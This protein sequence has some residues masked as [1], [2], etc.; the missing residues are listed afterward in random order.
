MPT[1][2][3]NVE[4]LSDWLARLSDTEFNEFKSRLNVL[5]AKSVPSPAPTAT[6]ING[7]ETAI[8][9]PTRKR[10]TPKKAQPESNPKPTPAA[11][12]KKASNVNM[13]DLS[14]D[15]KPDGD[16]KETF[17][18]LT[19]IAKGLID[20]GKESDVIAILDKVN[21]PNRNSIPRRLAA[22]PS[23]NQLELIDQ[24]EQVQNA[25]QVPVQETPK[26]PPQRLSYKQFFKLFKEFMDANS[27]EAGIEIANKHGITT[28]ESF[29]KATD[30][31]ISAMLSEIM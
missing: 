4:I 10:T 7:T 30:D 13:G 31:Q 11:E 25:N 29:D 2:N 6:Q 8:A 19:E 21:A 15:V 3:L 23:E 22:V 20:D 18:R 12:T 5:E 24:L 1:I 27:R 17:K 16:Q 28:Q 14:V 26:A 9:K